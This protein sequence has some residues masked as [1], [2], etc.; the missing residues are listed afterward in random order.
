MR[1]W[2]LLR[3]ARPTSAMRSLSACSMERSHRDGSGPSAMKCSIARRGCSS[4][5]SLP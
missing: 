4:I 5:A 1:E 2:D 3:F